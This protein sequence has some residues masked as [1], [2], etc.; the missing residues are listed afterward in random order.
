M[1]LSYR[2]HPTALSEIASLTLSKI[3]MA[4]Y[5]E[6]VGSAAENRR[7]VR[8]LQFFKYTASPWVSRQSIAGIN[9]GM[10]VAFRGKLRF[11][12]GADS[13]HLPLHSH[14]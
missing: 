8:A 14:T 1:L 5:A 11:S 12:R 13:S 6:P 7:G 2:A 3:H 10:D 9:A 4:G